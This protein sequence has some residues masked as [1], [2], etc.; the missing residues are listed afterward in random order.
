MSLEPLLIGMTWRDGWGVDIV[1]TFKEGD[2]KKA[3]K[4]LIG[5][6]RRMVEAWKNTPATY[7]AMPLGSVVDEL[8][9]ALKPFDNVDLGVDWYLK[10][11]DAKKECDE[12]REAC[13][14]VGE[15]AFANETTQDDVVNLL[16]PAMMAMRDGKTST[17]IKEYLEGKAL[18]EA[19][20]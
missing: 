3:M 11:S 9:E 19:P 20:C 4:E 17:E 16:W 10:Y 6:A 12:Y 1:L 18:E 8:E 5:K 13:Q 2:M 14:I 7:E 15:M